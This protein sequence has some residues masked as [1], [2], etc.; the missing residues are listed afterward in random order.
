M[1]VVLP[2][3]MLLVTFMW[4]FPSHSVP[5]VGL[6]LPYKYKH[7]PKHFWRFW[8][9]SDENANAQKPPKANQRV[10]RTPMLP[11]C[12]GQKACCSTIVGFPS[13]PSRRSS[14]AEKERQVPKLEK[15]SQHETGRSRGIQVS[16]Q[17][18]LVIKS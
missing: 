9:A 12:R 18:W 2:A 14:C 5:V 15:D 17:F 10:N 6:L 3:L 1:R 7:I 16:V 11:S 4:N 8:T 13:G